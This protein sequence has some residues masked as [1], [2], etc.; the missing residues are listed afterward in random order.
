MAPFEVVVVSTE[1]QEDVA[2]RVYDELVSD[3]ASPVD[4]IL[5]DRSDKQMGWKLG[6]ADLIGYPVIVVIGKGWKKQQTL[7]VQCRRLGV[8]QDV[9]FK[10][11]SSVVQSLLAQL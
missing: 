11:L 1:G 8:R 5:D 9:A 6:D 7:E 2:E 3:K 10:D 4:A